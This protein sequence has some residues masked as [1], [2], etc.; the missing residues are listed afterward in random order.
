MTGI[1]ARR[2][3]WVIT[4][5]PWTPGSGSPKIIHHNAEEDTEMGFA[6][7]PC[8]C[9]TRWSELSRDPWTS[10]RQWRHT[11]ATCSVHAVDLRESD[12]PI[13]MQSDTPIQTA[14]Q[15]PAIR[16][17]T[18]IQTAST[19]MLR[20]YLAVGTFQFWRNINRIYC[21][22]TNNWPKS[23]LLKLIRSID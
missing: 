2:S 13:Q 5:L 19:G 18:P 9:V 12:T 21:Y 14:S 6:G 20:S 23:V 1:R 11:H 10:A 4:S 16:H 22:K 8:A 3:S 7:V 15:L 17:D